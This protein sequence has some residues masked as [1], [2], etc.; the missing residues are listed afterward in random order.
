MSEPTAEVGAAPAPEQP[1]SVPE[2]RSEEPTSVPEVKSGDAT[3]AAETVAEN[4]GKDG[5]AADD[6]TNKGAGEAA[7]ANDEKSGNDEQ[8]KSSG[9]MLKT[10]ARIDPKNFAVNRKFDPSVLPDTDDPNL[11]RNQVRF[12][13]PLYIQPS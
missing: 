10:K 3:D 9:T 6:V 8:A 12:E 5:V 11:I 1:T 2:I 7:G 4:P 13:W